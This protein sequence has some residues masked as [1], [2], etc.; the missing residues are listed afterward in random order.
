MGAANETKLP[1]ETKDK[2]R[3]HSTE[4]LQE[5]NGDGDVQRGVLTNLM[6]EAKD[7][8]KKHVAELPQGFNGDGEV[9]HVELTSLFSEPEDEETKHVTELLVN[10]GMVLNA[11]AEAFDTLSGAVL[12]TNNTQTDDCMG[13]AW[14]GQGRARPN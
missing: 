8:E 5:F 12:P 6:S 2:E 10:K 4:F 9:Q 1:L 3:K 11:E 14:W 7:K 13:D